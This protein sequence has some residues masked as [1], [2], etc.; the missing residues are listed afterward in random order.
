MSYPSRDVSHRT[1]VPVSTQWT[2]RRRVTHPKVENHPTRRFAVQ[3]LDSRGRI[4]DMIRLAPATALFDD[5][6][7]AFGRGALVPTVD[8]PVA[9]EDLLPGVLVDTTTGLAPLL[10]IGSMA[11][12]P[13]SAAQDAAPIRMYRI[14]ADAFGLGR[15]M[16]DLLLGPGA[17]LLNRAPSV[18]ASHGTDAILERV[19][20]RADGQSV[21]EIQPLSTVQVFHLGFDR[22]RTFMANG[23]EVDS[24]HPGRINHNRVDATQLAMYLAM[25]PHVRQINEFGRLAFPRIA[26]GREEVTAA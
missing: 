15:P 21:I 20:S 19:G 11:V 8:G 26:A 16:P 13:G 10:W 23:V 7:S 1:A 2:V 25:F 24:M 12:V 9:V 4:D 3:W 22:H 5:A 6:F 14:P 18:R 17:R